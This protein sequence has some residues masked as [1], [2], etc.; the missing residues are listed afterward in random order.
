L[1]V[2]GPLLFCVGVTLGGRIGGCV[3]AGLVDGPVDIRTGADGGGYEYDGVVGF[4]FGVEGGCDCD[5]DDGVVAGATVAG[6][7]PGGTFEPEC[8][9]SK[10]TGTA[11]IATTAAAAASGA[12]ARCR[13]KVFTCA[14]CR[15]IAPDSVGE[16]ARAWASSDSRSWLSMSVMGAYP[17]GSGEPSYGRARSSDPG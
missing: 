9:W 4:G 2:G 8:R 10:I 13:R 1:A 3:G 7:R 6:G 14:D 16:T 5:G 17:A 12:Y 15:I 11:A